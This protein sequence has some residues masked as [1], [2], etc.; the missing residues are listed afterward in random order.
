MIPGWMRRLAKERIKILMRLA[1][2]E[3]STH[4]ERSRR[5][6]ELA[7]K[8]GMKYKVR[9]PRKYKRRIC[10]ECG[11]YLKPGVNCTVRLIPRERIVS[12]KCGNCGSERRYPYRKE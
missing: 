2:E 3:V 1:E 10:R 5:Y 7:R 4:P 12:W 11:A 8:L 9:P 6:V